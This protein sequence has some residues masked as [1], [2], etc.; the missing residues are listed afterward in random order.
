MIAAMFRYL[1]EYS[2]TDFLISREANMSNIADY[3]TQAEL[4]LAAYAELTT[5]RPNIE[6]LKEAGMTQTQAEHFAD[7]WSVIDQLADTSSGFS[8]TIFKNNTTGKYTLAIRGS[9]LD[10]YGQD[11]LR[12][13]QLIAH[14][15]VAARQLVDQYNFW[16]RANTAAGATYT[17]ATL[18]PTASTTPGAFQIGTVY[19]TIERVPSN[20]LTDPT[21]RLGTGAL[22]TCPA[23]I[24]VVGHSLGGHLAMAF[25]RLFPT[26]AT[27]VLAVNGLGFKSNTTVNNLFAQL[28]GA[29]SF[30]SGDIEN[31]YGI[32][33]PEFAAMNN[34]VLL[35]QPG[36]WDGIYIESA[37]LLDGA[38]GH[39]VTQMTDSLAIYSL[40]AKLSPALQ[41]SAITA[42]I[43]TASNT[44]D[45]SLES[46]LDALRTLLMDGDIAKNTGKQTAT[47][48]R[49]AFYTNLYALQNNSNYKTLSGSAGI[50]ALSGSGL[51]DQAKTDF[52]NFLAL[53]YLLPFTL[54]GADSV[55]IPTHQTEYDAWHADQSLTPAQKAAGE[56]NYTDAWYQDRAAMLG[57][58]LKENEKDQ[59]YVDSGQSLDGA[60]E[61]RDE[62]TGK[63]VVVQPAGGMGGIEHTVWFG[64]DGESNLAGGNKT[65]RLYGMGAT[66]R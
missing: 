7:E 38:W 61:F 10:Q 47:G 46:C 62:R 66:T 11:F 35:Q 16:Q 37:G 25:S 23:S 54:V 34:D 58:V 50:A 22:T 2:N 48:D 64:S 59:T 52:G 63:S 45:R 29:T 12:D 5:G 14:D 43:E 36:G 9:T 24:D 39:S 32:A 15:G 26:I 41:L 21:L 42:L 30:K 6:G 28:G 55:L 4:S 31:V 40:Y 18:T 17:A 51:A 13:Y 65:D 27:D 3:F 60:W 44:A 53:D 1:R 57:W 19:Y 49:N 20:Q 56:G 8:A 33:G